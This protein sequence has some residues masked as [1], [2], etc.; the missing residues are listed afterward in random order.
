MIIIEIIFWLSGFL[1]VYAFGLYKPLLQII[2]AM[3]KDA[4]LAFY[5]SSDEGL[6]SVTMVISAFN[7]EAVIEEKLNNALS[8]SYPQGKFEVV[9]ISD[10]SDD[11]TDEIVTSIA[12]NNSQVK[13]VR[14]SERLGKTSG[15]NLAMEDISTQLVV[16]SDANAMYQKDA[17]YEL[18]KYFKDESVGYIV[19]AALYNKEYSNLA[20]VSESEYW[21][22][23]LHIKDMEAQIVSVVG[24]DGAI[25]AI[26]KALYRPLFADDINDFANPLQIVAAGFR[27]AFNSKAICFEDSAES[28]EKEYKRKR[29]IVNRSFRALSRYIGEFNLRDHKLFLFLLFSHKVFR[30][31]SGVFI[32]LCLSCAVI[33][34]LTG[35]GWFYYLSLFI[36]LL[37]MA[38]A[39]IGRQFSERKSKL[40]DGGNNSRSAHALT[41]LY[42]FYL[43][44]MGALLGILDN[45]RGKR[46]VTWDHIRKAN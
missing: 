12:E 46:H 22:A 45:V 27:G 10:A 31:F 23:E 20:N 3:K 17:V 19:G 13:L 6:P 18:V 5:E 37:S 15:I 4:P 38:M 41:M 35:S 36:I 14:Q 40:D 25:Y 32:L 21:D 11:R 28:F 9:V 33:L 2:T 43:V 34:S 44:N 16:F 24:G 1:V 30:W 29:R 42:Y 39:L 7:E 8:I 26:R